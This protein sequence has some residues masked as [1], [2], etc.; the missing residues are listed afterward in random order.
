MSARFADVA[1]AVPLRRTFTYRI[2]ED[3][4]SDVAPGSRVA[5]PF[6]RR[7][8][9]GIVHALRDAPP[10]GLDERKVLRIAGLLDPYP[11]FPDEL[12][13]FLAEAARY[14][15][16]PIG[17]VY[18]AAS[19]PLAKGAIQTLRA[20]GFL[21]P[22]ESLHAPEIATRERLLVAPADGESPPRAGLKQRAAL[23]ILAERGE[24]TWSELRTLSGLTRGSLRRL[25]A[26]G[27]VTT[28]VEEVRADPFFAER[29]APDAPKTPTEEQRVAVETLVSAL[30]EGGGYLLH[31]VTGSG[32]TEVYLQVMEAALAEERGALLLVP[33]IALTPQLVGRVRARFGD[34][35]AVLHSGLG[36]RARADAWR[37]LREGR[38]RVAIGARSALFAPVPNLGLIV[39][40]EEHDPSF[41]QERGFTYHAR[42]MALL[43]AHRA[44]AVCV[45]GSATPSLESL[46]LAEA[47]RLGTLRLRARATGASMPEVEILD[48][49]RISGKPAGHPLISGPLLRALRENT[50]RGERAILF[51]NR[52]GFATSLHCGSCGAVR[53]CPSCSVA[54]TEHRRAAQLR[55][56]YCGYAEDIG[57]AC[58]SCGA[59]DAAPV[60]LGTE[61]LAHALTEAIPGARVGR[62]DRDTATGAGA[63]AILSA[64]RRG[65]LDILVGTQMVTKGH[66][67]PT[68]TL[69]GVI[70]ADHALGFPDFRAAERTYQLVSQVAGR[71]GRGD[72][73]GRVFVQT[74]QPEHHAI[75]HAATH[76]FDAFA[77]EELSM[78]R[79][80]GYPPFGH[81]AAIRMDAPTERQLRELGDTLSRVVRDTDDVRMMRVR[82]LGP[83]PAPIARIRDRYRARALLVGSERSAL[84][85][86]ALAAL[87]LA[88]APPSGTRLTLDIDPVS[89]L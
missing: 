20:R 16:H 80:I 52:R 53:E 68:V 54:L 51:L 86:V 6:A 84:R 5:V 59:S 75:R 21:A 67:I 63:A 57:A 78:R 85:R 83:A 74:F 50:E 8:V 60:G 49:R 81:V 55:C 38:V 76:D 13:A 3:H 47:G 69:V 30:G 44:D 39:V 82:V 89:M 1:V 11:L 71:A 24:L 7:K 10:E 27:A 2:P 61:Q 40:D 41:K 31:G 17:E 87:P 77:D 72:L 36:D 56:H 66:D 37:A 9:A 15:L 32:K 4:L 29:V 22:D 64:L 88:D 25:E 14:Y 73:A 58:P 48:L 45:L 33:E 35:I 23:A 42:D 26:R 65:E 79:A 18:R 12:R 43:R 62:L 46:A 34:G 28:R 19:P 70:L